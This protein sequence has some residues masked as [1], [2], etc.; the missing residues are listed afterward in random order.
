ME[1]DFQKIG[2]RLKK[3]REAKHLTQEQLAEL[4]DLSVSHISAVENASSGV[5]LQTFVNIVNKLELPIDWVIYGD[6]ENKYYLE[7]EIRQLFADC[8][9][10]EAELYLSILKNNKSLIKSFIE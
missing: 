5:K 8:T 9:E 4:T 1:L 2:E 7:G 10:Q 6:Y 3:G